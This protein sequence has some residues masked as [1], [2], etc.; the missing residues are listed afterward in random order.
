MPSIQRHKQR[1]PG[2]GR[3]DGGLLGRA[4]KLRGIREHLIVVPDTDGVVVILP[5]AAPDEDA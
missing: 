1:Y 3:V 2:P 5:V 4:E